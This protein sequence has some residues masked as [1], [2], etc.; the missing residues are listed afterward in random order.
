MAQSF[1]D[2]RIWQDAYSLLLKVYSLSKDFPRHESYILESQL[3][4]AALSIV[5]NIAESQG[6]YGY[7]DKIQFLIVARGSVEET[8]SHLSVALGLGYIEKKPF[9][10]LD[11]SYQNVAKGI[12]S[13]VSYIRRQK[14][15]Q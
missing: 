13:L 4:K 15:Q 9:Q 1:R 10:L 7:Q 2:L 8:R 6:R 3:K 14:N 12:N 11:D 5:A